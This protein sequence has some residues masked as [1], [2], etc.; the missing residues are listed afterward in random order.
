MVPNMH[1]LPRRGRAIRLYQFSAIILTIQEA[2]AGKRK[3]ENVGTSSRRSELLTWVIEPL[4][5]IRVSRLHSSVTENL[6]SQVRRCQGL[7]E[8]YGCLH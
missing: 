5:A 2:A 1:H 3:G 7:S 8:S 4:S 6:M